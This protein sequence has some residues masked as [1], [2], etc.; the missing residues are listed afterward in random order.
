MSDFALQFIP[1]E[2]EAKPELPRR[3]TGLVEQGMSG[4]NE[5]IAGILGFPADAVAGALNTTT[6]GVNRLAG[7]NI[8]KIEKPVGGRDFFERLLDF[9]ISDEAPQTTGQRYARR[10]GQEVGFGVPLTLATMGAGPLSQMA[11]QAPKTFMAANTAADV[12]AGMAGQTAREIAPENN[13]L[14]AIVSLLAGTGTAMGVDRALTRTPPAPTRADVEARTNDLYR[15]VENSGADLTPQAQGDFAASLRNRFAAE[16]G[17][18]LAY[19]K[20][21]AQLGVIENNPRPSVYGI[22]QARRR[23][24]DKVARSPDESAIGQDL[25]AEIDAYLSNLQPNQI[26]SNSVDPQEVVD[27]L[28]QARASAHTGIK[29]DEV[30]DAINRANS[31]TSTTGT[32]GNSLNAQSQEI[33]KLYDQETSLRRPQKSGGYTPDEVAAMERIVFPSRGERLLQRVGRF[34]PTTGALQGMATAASGGGGLVG[35]LLSGNPL[36]MAAAAPSA[37][38]MVAQGLAE[39]AKAKNIEALVDTILRGGTKAVP[40]V[41]QGA[42]AA[43]VSQLLNAPQ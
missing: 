26:A 35:A 40:Q 15:R 5:G 32:A 10:V 31:R 23:V 12:A 41:N 28:L 18:P 43:I 38:G 42:R 16:G 20:A 4:V 29:A 19:P 22:E 13:T 27:T 9:S 39:R 17:D 36:W 1:G 37:A 34:S 21:N 7:T 24:R 8:G 30:T 11:M 2:E 25:V 3:K 14:D 33:R 6:G